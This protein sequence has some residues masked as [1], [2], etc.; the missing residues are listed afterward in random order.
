MT[1]LSLVLA[2]AS[3][4]IIGNKNALPWR[5]PEDM[6][7]FKKVT[8]GKPVIMGRKTWDSLP[9]KFRPLPG[10]RNIVVTRD[11]TWQK[12]GAERVSSLPEALQSCSIAPEVCVIG[13][14]QIYAE[15][16]PLAQRV[17]LTEI[18]H[19]FEGDTVFAAL[20]PS[21]WRETARET[22]KHMG[23]PSFDVH[24]VTYEREKD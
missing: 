5:L 7:H 20:D 10:R 24:F 23:Q 22:I 11:G 3:N 2:R 18:D 19:A 9:E 16:L 12:A 21:H 1:I 15:A 13:G 17:Y 4:G 6:A 14:A 8:L